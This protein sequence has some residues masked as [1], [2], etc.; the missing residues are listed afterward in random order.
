M[1]SFISQVVEETLATQKDL[2]KL[3]FVLP[4]QRACV[5]V[6]NEFISKIPRAAFLPKIISIETFVQEV[7]KMQLMDNTQLL[8]EFYGVYL[9][10]AKEKEIDSFDVFSQWASIALHDFNELDSYLVDPRSF[11][12]NLQDIKKL[13]NWFQDKKPSQLAINYLDFFN[14]LEEL[15]FGLSNELSQKKTGYQGLLYRVAANA[16]SNY[17]KSNNS[18]FVFAGFNALNKSEEQIFQELLEMNMAEVYWDIDSNMLKSNNEAGQ[19]IRN[20]KSKWR[21][22]AKNP[23]KRVHNQQAIEQKINIVGA[24][25][26]ITQIKYVGELLKNTGDYQ[27]T[28]LVLGDEKLLG[29]AANA[30]PKKVD[31]INITMGYP[32]SEIPLSVLFERLFKMYLNQVKF[33]KQESNEF[34]YKDVL[35]VLNDPFLNKL[36]GNLMQEVILKIKKD[37]AIFI[38]TSHLEKLLKAK[39]QNFEVLSLFV[40]SS[41]VK[42]IIQSCIRFLKVLK[43]AVDGLEKEYVYRFYAVFQQLETLNSRY[44]YI[45]DLK[46]L[47]HFYK[48]V[49]R[50][51]SLSFQGEPLQGLQLMGLLE[52]RALDFKNIIMTSLNEGILPGGKSDYSFIPHD[53]KIFFQLPTYNEK[54]AIFSYHF[55]RLLQRAENIHLIYNTETDGYGSGEKSRFLTRLELKNKNVQSKIVSPLVEKVSEDTVVIEKTRDVE[56]KLRELFKYGIS[57]SALASYVYNPIKFYEQKV[58]KIR[59]DELVEETI[60]VNTMGSVIHDTLEDLYQPFLNKFVKKLDIEHMEKSIEP[61]LMRFFEKHYP[62]GSTAQGKNKLIFE[63]CKAHIQRFLK[64]EKELVSKHQL[65]IIALEAELNQELPI[66]GISSIINVKGIVDRI[67][68]L[69]GVLRIIDYKTGKVEAKELKMSDFSLV[70]EDY[71]YTKAMQVMLYAFMFTQSSAK[72]YETIESGVISF[73]NLNSGFLKMNFSENY[74]VKDNNVSPERIDAFLVEIKELIKEILDPNSPFVENKNLPF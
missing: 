39:T 42:G 52:T 11:F 19:F 35:S 8:F 28:A 64:Q 16:I 24:P 7:S 55:Q 13:N 10:V 53:I 46:T 67:D 4:S 61:L 14:V 40:F 37:N 59:E 32:L 62:K 12:S 29:L 58:L 41:N 44:N 69:D 71:K 31:K 3:T 15:Y 48:E 33:S 72:K 38:A 18:F 22:Y 66:D 20:Y 68:E 5:F 36:E 23:I 70:K 63:V 60:A 73:K 30:L 45:E 17:C 43:D 25:K 6:K 9:K 65:K 34:Y 47:N 2:G 26:N 56:D 74:R 27:N 50:N 54:D 1:K 21:Y 57:P 51:E 49:L